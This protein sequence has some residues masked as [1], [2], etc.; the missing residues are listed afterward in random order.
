MGPINSV[1]YPFRLIGWSI[2]GIASSFLGIH[3][4]RAFYLGFLDNRKPLQ[5]QI[6]NIPKVNDIPDFK[7]ALLRSQDT[8]TSKD[9]ENTIK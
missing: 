4:T 5:V 1:T 6:D 3:V 7:T 8:N 9:T 2:F